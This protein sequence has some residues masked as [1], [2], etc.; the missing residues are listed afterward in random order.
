MTPDD[1]AD[2]CFAVLHRCTPP[3]GKKCQSIRKIRH[4]P[5]LRCCPVLNNKARRVPGFASFLWIEYNSAVKSLMA[6]LRVGSSPKW[7]TLGL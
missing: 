4:R 6:Q 2:A 3:P 7:P 1:G 5:G